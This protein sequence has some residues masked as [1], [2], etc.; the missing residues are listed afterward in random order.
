MFLLMV[1]IA[2]QA[3]EVKVLSAEVMKPLR[4]LW[5]LN[6]R[7]SRLR[8]NP[9]FDAGARR[10]FDYDARNAKRGGAHAW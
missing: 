10:K 6:R 9:T 2:A 8:K 3:A 5:R 7:A 4:S 1:G